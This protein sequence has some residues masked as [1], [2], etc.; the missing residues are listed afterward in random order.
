MTSDRVQLLGLVLFVVA[1]LV[2]P[3]YLFLAA[4]R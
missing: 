4:A 1:F 3:A 2:G